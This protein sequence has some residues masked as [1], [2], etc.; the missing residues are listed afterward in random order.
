[1]DPDSRFPAGCIIPSV[2]FLLHLYFWNASDESVV[3]ILAGRFHSLN[4]AAFVVNF[5]LLQVC[6]TMSY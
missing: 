4:N 5:T 2:V 1:M 6:K 3:A